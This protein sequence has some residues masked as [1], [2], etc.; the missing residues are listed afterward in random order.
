MRVLVTGSAGFGGSHFVEHVLENTDWEIIGLDSFRHRGDPLRVPHLEPSRYQVFTADLA[1]PLGRLEHSLGNIDF[2]VNYASE[3]H[4]DRSI[5]DPVPFVNNNVG[6]SLQMLELARRLKPKVFI[7]VS[8]DEVYGPALP[9]QD[10]PEWAP[11][12]PSNPYAAS[13]AAQE[14]LSIAWWRTYG[15]P[16]VIV[17]CMNLIGERQDPEKMVPLCIQRIARGET[18]PIHVGPDGK[19]GSRYYLHARNLA[20]AILFLL[21]E[22]YPDELLYESNLKRPLRFNIVGEREVDNLELAQM[23]AGFVGRPLQHEFTD[24]HSARPGH[25]PRYGLD[26]AKLAALGWKPPVLFEDSLRKT[27]EWTLANNEWL[28]PIG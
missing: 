24:W 13:K 28:V 15:V 20:D 2:I 18:V 14:A 3:S 1:A 17:N 23:I 4:V 26:G 7:Q 10:H 9:D 11:I 27:V 5:D 6:L 19:P 25:D 8:T 12:L 16:V 22:L 21:S